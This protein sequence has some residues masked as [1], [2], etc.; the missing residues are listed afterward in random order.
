MSLFFSA[1][2]L[3]SENVVGAEPTHSQ[4]KLVRFRNN[5]Y[6]GLRFP[7]DAT[8]S[9]HYRAIR[10]ESSADISTGRSVATIQIALYHIENLGNLCMSSA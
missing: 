8:G 6:R 7:G 3:P 9:Y 4:T 1:S 5:C 10:H 2:S